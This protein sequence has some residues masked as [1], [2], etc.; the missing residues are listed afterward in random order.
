MGVRQSF[1]DVSL[2][3]LTEQSGPGFFPDQLYPQWRPEML[4]EMRDLL[5]P[6]SFDEA[7]G[8]F[9]ASIHTWIV[10]V[11]GQTVLIDTCSG[12]DKERPGMPRFHQQQRD[13]LERLRAAGV[14]PEAVDFVMCTHLHADHCGWN[15][16]LRNGRWVPT[17]PNARYVF[18]KEENDYWSAVPAPDPLHQLVYADSVLP[19]VEAGQTEII[20]PGDEA[21]RD[22]MG[23]MRTPGHSPGHLAFVLETP[24][25][26]L[27]FSGDVMHQPV[28]I[29]HP[30]L[31]TSFCADPAEAIASR[32]RLLD[33]AS[34]TGALVCTAHFTRSSKG[35]V[36]RTGERYSWSFA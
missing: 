3:R 30:E 28:Q 15:T 16:Q 36:T 27:I 19:V 2:Q 24:D 29:V 17:F 18:S 4:E 31:T 13:Y 32:S 1:G 20:M 26:P 9:I 25:T 34:D 35:H 10:T 23:I 5:I 14:A 11:R 7:S 33:F 12:N 21:V 22:L 6:D 8:R